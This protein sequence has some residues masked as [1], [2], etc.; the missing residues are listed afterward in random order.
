MVVVC[1]LCVCVR[2]CVPAVSGEDVCCGGFRGGGQSQPLSSPPP[3]PPQQCLWFRPLPLE[4][5]DGCERGRAH[6]ECVPTRRQETTASPLHP[7]VGPPRVAATHPQTTGKVGDPASVCQGG[8]KA[9]RPPEKSRFVHRGRRRDSPSGW[10]VC[11]FFV[12]VCVGFV[13]CGP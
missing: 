2:V 7:G 9:H 1:L 13:V 10:V 12:F 3:P 11:V 5:G 8:A 6:R 4:R